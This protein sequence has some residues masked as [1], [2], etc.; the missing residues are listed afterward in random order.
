MHKAHAILSTTLF[1][2]SEYLHF[3]EVANLPGYGKSRSADGIACSIWPSR[4]HY[5]TGFEI[6][7]SRGDWL[8]EMKTPA[9]ADS[10]F[11]R[12]GY[13]YL[14]TMADAVIAKPEEI[15]KPWGHIHITGD[16]PKVMK[17]APFN[18][19]AKELD[20]FMICLLRRMQDQIPRMAREIREHDSEK[21][22]QRLRQSLSEEVRKNCQLLREVEEARKNQ[23]RSEF[24]AK[25]CKALDISYHWY[26]IQS[27]EDRLVKELQAVKDAFRLNESME[28]LKREVEAKQLLLEEIKTRLQ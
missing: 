16:K 15:P 19:L 1:P 22:M 8:K 24:I 27:S 3:S 17:K 12:C 4:G 5:L 25:V 20:G 10:F 21:E 9:K 6:K 28:H 2:L 14:V 18:E 7:V 13:W 11:K 23:I 26:G